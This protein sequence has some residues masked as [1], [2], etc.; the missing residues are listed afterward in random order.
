MSL[1]MFEERYLRMLADRAAT[2][3]AF[4]VSLI[5]S[6][7][8]VADQP[9]VRAVGTTARLVTINAIADH[10]VELVVAG[11]ERVALG[12]VSWEQG[13]ATADGVPLVDLPFDEERGQALAEQQYREYGRLLRLAGPLFSGTI[14]LPVLPI[15]PAR[16]AYE[17]ARWLPV[18]TAE[19]QHLL[20]IVDPIER[21]EW[22][23]WIIRRE[24]RLLTRGG[25]A[26]YP[27]PHPGAR[28]GLN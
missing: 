23:G 24:R 14:T 13:Y 9:S 12:D 22:V 26:A 8:E 1:R 15:D 3:P 19:Q 18:T 5:I 28:F 7:N 16:N 6:G 21:L 2:E 25:V 11:Q 4:A 17:L 27:L 10:V 20:E